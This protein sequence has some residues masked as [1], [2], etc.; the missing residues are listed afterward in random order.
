MIVRIMGQGQWE[1]PAG[2]LPGLNALDDLVMDAVRDRDAD[3][4]QDALAE[5]IELV[6]R[7][8]R[9]IETNRIRLSDLIVPQADAGLDEVAEWLQEACAE[10][11]LIPG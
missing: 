8:G 5:M 1:L 6:R 2:E 3:A 11:G 9:R 4:L 10:D 7:R